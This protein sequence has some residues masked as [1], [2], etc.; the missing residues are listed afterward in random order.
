MLMLLLF[1]GY[2][3]LW[4]LLVYWYLLRHDLISIIGAVGQWTYVVRIDKAEHL[5]VFVE[6]EPVVKIYIAYGV[7]FGRLSSIVSI[8]ASMRTHDDYAN[9]SVVVS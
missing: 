2:K 9:A 1:L 5:I 8:F 4:L 6:V 3:Q 7:H